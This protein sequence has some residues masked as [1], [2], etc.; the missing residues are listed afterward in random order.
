M[1]ANIVSIHRTTTINHQNG[2]GSGKLGL[3]VNDLFG[4]VMGLNVLRALEALVA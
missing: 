3:D 1:E 2:V 4:I